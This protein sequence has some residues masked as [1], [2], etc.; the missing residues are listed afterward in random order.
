MDS[1]NDNCMISIENLTK[2]Y[3]G[4]CV[5]DIPEL[6]IMEGETVGIVGN[7][8]AGKTT[9]F[10][11]LLDLIRPTSGVVFSEGIPVQN[12]DH[13]KTYTGS[14]LDESFLLDYLSP[15]EFFSFAG[16]LYGKSE[17]DIQAFYLNMSGIF[18]DEILDKNKYIRDLSKGN[19]KKTGITAALI[20]QP[21]LLI[22]DEPFT[23]LDPS[24]QIRLKQM[25]LQLNRENGM[26]MLISSHD[27]NHV[28][29]VCNRI[30]VIDKGKIVRDLQTDT[31]TRVELEKF[32]TMNIAYFASGCFWGTEYHFMKANGVTATTVGF[33]GG[34]L[35]HPTYEQVCTQTTGHLET[36]EVVFDP[37]Q[38]NYESLV[39][40]FFE[41]HDFCQTDGQG[42]DIGPQYRSLIFYQTEEQRKVAEKYIEILKEKG[43]QV[44]TELQEASAFWKAEDYHQQYYA[45]KGALPYCHTYK[46]IF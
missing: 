39:K 4:V 26:T 12:S 22:L 1:E 24:S 5:L 30:V 17:A 8:G 45:H 20:G 46:K 16:S 38:T 34:H 37:L 10:R 18:N 31:H 21:K 13:W 3:N 33:M 7:N 32:F 40:L 15:E 28:T 42:P 36:V 27:L 25:L 11:A 14:F 35:H 23:H 44:A 43:Y 9:L 2:L 19:Q 29:E 6:H 41:T